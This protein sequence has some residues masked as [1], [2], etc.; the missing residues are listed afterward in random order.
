MFGARR[1]PRSGGLFIA[2]FSALSF[3]FVED[4]DLLVQPILLDQRKQ[5]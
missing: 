1:C 4:V 3:E 2:F 5:C